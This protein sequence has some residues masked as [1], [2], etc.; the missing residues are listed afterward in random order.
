[1]SEITLSL[2]YYNDFE[3]L[4]QH[5]EQWKAYKDKIEFQIIDDG[6][7]EKLVD[8]IDID[9]FLELNI[10]IYRIN[11]D[12]KWNIPGVRNLGAA[13]CS[14][15]WILFCDMDQYFHERDINKIIN[16]INTKQID[17]NKYYSFSRS[18]R[19]RTAGTLMMTKD[20][21]WKCGAYDEDLRGNYGYNDPLLRKQLEAIDVQEETLID[22]YCQQFNA[23]C[24]LDRKGMEKNKRKMH[25][26]IK[27]LPKK[28]IKILD[29]N[30]EKS[31]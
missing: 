14:T 19:E 6:S 26:K 31:F 4:H 21:F 29:F 7:K 28:E 15:K 18:G 11:Q 30:W 20:N 5:L 10:S 27:K 8:K 12:I 17:D 13:A 3:H 23:D 2:S 1:M 25:R 24:L 22:V 9:L 16:K